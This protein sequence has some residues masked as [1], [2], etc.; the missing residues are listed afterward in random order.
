MNQGI[1]ILAF[2][3]PLLVA[4]EIPHG[5]ECEGYDPKGTGA[6]YERGEFA[7]LRS[8]GFPGAH[9][10]ARVVDGDCRPR[11]E[12]GLRKVEQVAEGREDEEGYGVED[13][14]DAER[15]GHFVL[16]CLEHAPTAAIA[17]PPHMAVP[18]EMR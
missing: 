18:E 12:L 3:S 11:S 10:G 2:P 17:L 5:E 7:G 16:I 8:V 6:F 15:D 14:D 9:H 1:E 4:S 13:E